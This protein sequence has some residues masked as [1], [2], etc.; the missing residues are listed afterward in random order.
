MPYALVFAETALD[1]IA[2]L[3]N[4]LPAQRQEAALDAIADVCVTFANRPLRR[5]TGRAPNF[6]LHFVVDV[7]HYHWVA[8][9]QL[10]EDETTVTVTHVFR[11]LL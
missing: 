8:T 2:G 5:S 9:Y 3:I 1:D 11:L 7:V 4:T 6:P 10:S